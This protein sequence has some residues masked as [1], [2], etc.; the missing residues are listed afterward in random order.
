MI[1]KKTE[2]ALLKKN[3]WLGICFSWVVVVF[4]HVPLYY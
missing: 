1:F 4:R 3:G 2:L